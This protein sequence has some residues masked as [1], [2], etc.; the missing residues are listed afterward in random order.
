VGPVIVIQ[1]I[2]PA[3]GEG[4]KIIRTGT[5]KLEVENGKQ[6]YKLASEIC[7]E[8]GGYLASS[9]FYKDKEGREAGTITMRIPKDK[10]TTA[11]DR[12]GALGKV[13]NISTDSQDV[14]QE[15]AALKSQ[16]DAALV[17]YNKMLEALQKRQVTIPEAM[18]LESELT[19]ILNRVA[20]LKNK[21]EY[22]NN[23]VSFTTVTINFH[24]P[25]ISTKTLAE[26]RRFV[27]ESL[28][29]AAANAIRFLAQAL[30][31]VIVVLV[32]LGVAFGIVLVAKIIILRLF[33]RG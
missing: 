20:Q 5:I 2:I 12:L 33:K 28:I 14:S 29:S 18:R 13:E 21:I 31:V 27:K 16:L 24:E 4:D 6:A 10:F 30:P 32:S 17:V 22:L 9:S 23:A 19:P 3:T 7:Q 26:S 11:L 15:Y 1:P 25:Q 8:L